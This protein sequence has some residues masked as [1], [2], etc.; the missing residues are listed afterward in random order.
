M[1]SS[2]RVAAKVS[3]GGTTGMVGAGAASVVFTAA[4]EST[5]KPLGRKIG[6]VPLLVA[7]TCWSCAVAIVHPS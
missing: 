4:I 3:K 2:G 5:A 7:K 6:V 1:G